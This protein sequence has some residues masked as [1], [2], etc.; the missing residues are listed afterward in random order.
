MLKVF[1]LGECGIG[2]ALFVYTS[3]VKL[4]SVANIR[5]KQPSESL[6]E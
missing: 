6:E 5:L 4:D 1:I 3:F 2:D